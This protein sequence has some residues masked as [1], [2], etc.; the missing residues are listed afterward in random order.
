MSRGKDAPDGVSEITEIE[1]FH[2]VD[3]INEREKDGENEMEQK[4]DDEAEQRGMGVAFQGGEKCEWG[5]E[6]NKVQKQPRKENDRSVNPVVS[7]LLPLHVTPSGFTHP[8]HD[9]VNGRENG[10][11]HQRVQS[12]GSSDDVEL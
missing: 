5:N 3:G 4:V 11:N 10:K 8:I 12:I 9:R 6:R 1:A 2:A 7:S